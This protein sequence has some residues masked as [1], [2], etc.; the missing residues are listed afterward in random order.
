MGKRRVSER[1][2]GKESRGGRRGRIRKKVCEGE[3]E[4]RKE[5]TGT[6]RKSENENER[7]KQ[8]ITQAS[9]Q[10]GRLGEIDRENQRKRATARLLLLLRNF[11][12]Y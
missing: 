6:R 7:K 10:A 11:Y 8:S 3:R 5:G 2:G 12:N 9:K 1:D 4:G